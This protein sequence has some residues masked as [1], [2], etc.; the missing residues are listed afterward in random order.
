MV[1]SARSRGVATVIVRVSFTPDNINILNKPC[2]FSGRKL[3]CFEAKV[4][5]TAS[6]KP[7]NPV[8]PV[9]KVSMLAL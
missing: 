3:Y 5:F 7:K 9:G 6:F 8:G 4:C 2:L 1:F